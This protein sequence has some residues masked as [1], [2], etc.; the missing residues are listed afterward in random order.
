MVVAG[1]LLFGLL[2]IGASGYVA[3]RQ[4]QIHV[5]LQTAQQ[6]RQQ[7]ARAIESHRMQFEQEISN[8]GSTA[9]NQSQALRS[10]YDHERR[11]VSKQLG[12]IRS[13][14]DS[15]EIRGESEAVQQ[16]TAAPESESVLPTH[17]NGVWHLELRSVVEADTSP[18]L[19]E[20]DK[21]DREG[22]EIIEKA[23]SRKNQISR[24][25]YRARL[26][27]GLE[28]TR[29]ASRLRAQA[30]RPDI[31]V[32]GIDYLGR[33]VT[34]TF[35]SQWKHALGKI[36]PGELLSCR[37]IATHNTMDSLEISGAEL[38]IEIE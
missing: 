1:A 18:L 32:T 37:G 13:R 5:E 12:L 4:E 28:L 17:G 3:Y 7:L 36:S 2:G 21:V 33:T 14:L 25:E 29:K 16:I 26:R 19:M 24:I 34:A 6:E 35:G 31:R 20:A 30:D 15:L 11:D 27:D 38:I 10:S 8:V 23:R 9:I 22:N